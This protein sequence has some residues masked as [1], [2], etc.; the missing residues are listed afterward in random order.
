MNRSTGRGQEYKEAWLWAWLTGA[1]LWAWL[2]GRGE[3]DRDETAL[4]G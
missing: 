1:W 2:T 4:R 3:R